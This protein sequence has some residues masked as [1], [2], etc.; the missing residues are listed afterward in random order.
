MDFGGRK[1]V[2]TAAGLFDGAQYLAGA[3]VGNGM[4]RLLDHFRTPT[5]AGSEFEVWP[6]AP[7][8]FAL[9]GAFLISRLWHVLPGRRPSRNPAGSAAEPDS[10]GAA[11]S[12]SA[13]TAGPTVPAVITGQPAE[14]SFALP[15]RAV[16]EP[17]T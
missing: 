8:P 5:S 14:Q 15:Q 3:V 11:A 16:L 17:E 1:A 6:L 9:L 13:L 12:S 2:A 7:L 4:G 10:P